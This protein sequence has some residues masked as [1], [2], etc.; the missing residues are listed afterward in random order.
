MLSLQ[1]FYQL[2]E[3]GPAG[4]KPTQYETESWLALKYSKVDST[5]PGKL[6]LTI[7]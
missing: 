4:M 1:Y 3:T 7:M 5:P 2:A 6:Q